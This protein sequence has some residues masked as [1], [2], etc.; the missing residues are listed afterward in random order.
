MRCISPTSLTGSVAL[1]L[2]AL[3]A[4]GCDT[5]FGKPCKLPKSPSFRA[6]CSQS[7]E[8]TDAGA[9]STSKSH[10]SCA[11]KEYAA[12]ETRVCLVYQGSSSYCSE[13]CETDDDCEGSARCRSLTGGTDCVPKAMQVP[14]ECYC[15]KKQ[16]LQDESGTTGGSGA[17]PTADAGVPAATPD[18]A[19]APSLAP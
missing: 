3:A 15:V 2:I 16:D 13:T 14:P 9:G 10:P 11:V 19:A 5:G 17:T 8:D 7:A 4:A 12:C 18:A 1:A 6:A